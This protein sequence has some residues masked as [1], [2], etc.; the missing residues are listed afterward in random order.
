MSVL[1]LQDMEVD[2]AITAENAPAQDPDS[3][4]SVSFCDE[5]STVSLVLCM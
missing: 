2:T 1:D 4:Y 3:L 5:D